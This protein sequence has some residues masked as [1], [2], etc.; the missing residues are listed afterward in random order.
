M[1]FR[2]GK[3]VLLKTVVQAIPL[4]VMSIF[5]IPLNFCVELERMVNSFW[6]GTNGMDH[7]G[8][9]WMSWDKLCVHKLVGGMGFQKL[10]EFNLA[11][12]GK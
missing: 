6:W 2:T 7:R 5:L 3:E 10:H 8:I 12:L 4:Y 11:M 9:H 1:S